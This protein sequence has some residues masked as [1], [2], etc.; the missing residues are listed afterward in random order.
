MA[1]SNCTVGWRRANLRREGK[2]LRK[3]YMVKAH[4]MT[5]EE[6]LKY[7]WERGYC[8]PA[9]CAT[10]DGFPTDP[11]EEEALDEGYDPCMHLVRLY[12]DHE[13]RRRIEENHSPT[14]WR[15]SNRGWDK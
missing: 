6:W 5:A 10:H 4:D 12:E 11:E 3:R 13:Q 9:L 2:R 14:Q 8:G 1:R 7:G 15:A